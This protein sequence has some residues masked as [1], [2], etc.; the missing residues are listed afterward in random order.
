M[1]NLVYVLEDFGKIDIKLKDLLEKKGISRNKLCNMM[2]SNYD[3]ITRYYNNR[4][5]R[6]DLEIIAKIC[7]VLDCNITDVLEYSTQ[8]QTNVYFFSAINSLKETTSKP[9]K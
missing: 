4:V 5:T 9:L 8:K 6:V 3:L 7:F 2:G 1:N